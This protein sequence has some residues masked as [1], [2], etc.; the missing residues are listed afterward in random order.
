MGSARSRSRHSEAAT[1][2]YTAQIERDLAAIRRAMRQ[3]LEAEYAKGDVTLPQRAVMQMVVQTPGITLK[4]LSRGISL[5]HST[6]S[7]IVHRL[8]KRGLIERV[9]D[10]ADRRLSRIHPSSA[11]TQFVRERIPVLR[12]SPL[13]TALSRASA[14]DRAR[15]VSALRRLRE[16]LESS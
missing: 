13:L 16:L 3:K 5:A 2:T 7:G 15:I 8:E 10:A 14:R 9:P 11:V 12:S 4:D 6:V 1:A